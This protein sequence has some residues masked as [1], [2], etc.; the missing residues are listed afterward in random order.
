[1]PVKPKG[2]DGD[3]WMTCAELIEALQKMP[4]N[5]LARINRMSFDEYQTIHNKVTQVGSDRVWIE[6]ASALEDPP[7]P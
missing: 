6:G 1:M 4:P 7:S 2:P 3:D 5:A